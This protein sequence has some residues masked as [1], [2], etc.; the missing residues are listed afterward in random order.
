MQ[1]NVPLSDKNQARVA[2]LLKFL[3]K[4]MV[5]KAKFSSI[6]ETSCVNKVNNLLEERRTGALSC[7]QG[8]E[9]V[10]PGVFY[11]FHSLTRELYFH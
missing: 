10:V 3:N 9:V 5:D 7:L 2:L 11:S 4:G 1:P 6:Q 8:N